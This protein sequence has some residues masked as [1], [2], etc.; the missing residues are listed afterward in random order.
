MISGGV[1]GEIGQMQHNPRG[2]RGEMRNPRIPA[3][4]NRPTE[5][6]APESKQ[7][8]RAIHAQNQRLTGERAAGAL[9]MGRV[10]REPVSRMR[11][12]NE[13]RS[14]NERDTEP[15]VPTGNVNERIQSRRKPANH[16]RAKPSR[17][18]REE[19]DVIRQY[20]DVPSPV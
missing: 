18:N 9:D 12:R 10:D 19:V 13:S 5:D 11:T 7:R 16:I 15:A 3:G 20:M 6:I 8:R 4:H 17:D 2:T 14:M 1:H